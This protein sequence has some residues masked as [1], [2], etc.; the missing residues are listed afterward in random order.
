[1]S[2]KTEERSVINL[3]GISLEIFAFKKEFLLV[4][5]QKI[6]VHIKVSI[7]ETPNEVIF[8]RNSVAR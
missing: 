4:D 8:G 6:E 2:L 3:E 5:E 7:L 1:M